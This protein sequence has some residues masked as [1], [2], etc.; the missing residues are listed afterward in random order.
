MAGGN[1]G[2]A[3]QVK[4]KGDILSFPVYQSTT[5]Y[6]GGPVA[7]NIS[8][9]FAVMAEDTANH[10]FVGIAEEGVDNSSGSDGDKIVRVRRKGI[11][12]VTKNAASAATDVGQLA[13]MHTAQGSST[14]FLVDLA[15]AV[16]NGVAVGL[17]VRREPD[18]PGGSAYTKKYLMVDITPAPWQS[19]DLT[20]HAAL[21]DQTAH[22]DAG[23]A[24]SQTTETSTTPTITA[25]EYMT[26]N[27]VLTY[28][29]TSTFTLPTSGITTGTQCRFVKG[30]S[31][32]GA[33]IITGG[34]LVGSG[35]V[36]NVFTGCANDGDSVVIQAVGTNSFRV[37]SVHQKEPVINAETSAT[38][39]IT[40]AEWYGGITLHTYAGAVAVTLPASGVRAGT[41]HTFVKNHVTAGLLTIGATALVGPQC[42][43][44]D[45]IGCP[46]NNDSVT[47]MC[48]GNDSYRVV[49]VSQQ[50]VESTV[51][52]STAVTALQFVGG[53]VVASLG[54]AQAITLP[55]SGV[56]VGA[57]CIFRRST[58]ASAVTISAT[59]LIGG[60]AS[61]NEHAACDAVG[62][63]VTIM[64]TGD[65]AYLVV[66]EAIA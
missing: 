62:D 41:L 40:A 31:T 12:R 17:I 5:I 7:I 43:S 15:A 50:L 21:T 14:D 32:A 47:I 49:N 61:G 29:G 60:A 6:R 37:V 51:A 65:D 2:N 59:T 11:F 36:S 8:H 1:L 57:K 28:A 27:V 3:V 22:Y 34:T 42:V 16:T 9:G 56:P 33:L 53:R 10:R 24:P 38:V 54:E 64:C 66:A 48:V 20:T 19:I 44:N 52:T 63:T 30:S 26:R 25:A 13:F 46:N 4:A 58:D 35:C 45:F 18:T 23:I 39:T 55:A